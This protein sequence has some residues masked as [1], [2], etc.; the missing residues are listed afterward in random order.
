[1]QTDER[2]D[3]LME[4]FNEENKSFVIMREINT[5]SRRDQNRT[6]ASEVGV[7]TSLLPP[8]PGFKS[9]FPDNNICLWANRG[10][11]LLMHAG[12]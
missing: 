1:M 2:L 7:L 10:A 4:K 3:G 8:R 5:V 12:K 11:R 6:G 9:A